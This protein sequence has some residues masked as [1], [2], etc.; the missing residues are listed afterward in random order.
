[1]KKA[2]LFT[3]FLIILLVLTQFSLVSAAPSHDVADSL[4]GTVLKIELNTDGSSGESAVWVTVVDD[5]REEQTVQVSLETALE[6]HIVVYEN[7][8]LVPNELLL[9]T[10]INIP[11]DS[12]IPDQTEDF[13][14]PVANAFATFFSEDIPGVNYDLIISAHEDGFGFGVIAQA[15]WMTKKL[16]GDADT[17]LKILEAK[18]TG[19]YSDITLEDGTTPTNWGQ[20]KQAVMDGDKKG[21]RGVIM[22]GKNKDKTNNGNGSNSGNTDNNIGN[23][24]NHGSNSNH[25]NT[26]NHGNA[27]DKGNNDNKTNNGN[28]NKP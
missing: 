12:I 4:S 28:K 7:D 14:H 18:Q 21:N 11:L 8:Q 19:D 1:M 24:G 10:N 6:W 23:N 3:S 20:F 13:K 25:G 26:S 2:K 16:D 15:L 5:N 9:N 22:S 17:L 27:G